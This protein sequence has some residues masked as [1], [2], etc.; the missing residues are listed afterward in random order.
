VGAIRR[1]HPPLLRPRSRLCATKAER[2]I[3]PAI[4]RALIERGLCVTLSWP[5]RAPA[6]FVCSLIVALI[7]IACRCDLDAL[8]DGVEFEIPAGGGR[9]LEI[10]GA[11]LAWQEA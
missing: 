1:I 2:S 5:V 8:R 3:S 6:P 9:V 4:M 7:Y 11:D 10:L